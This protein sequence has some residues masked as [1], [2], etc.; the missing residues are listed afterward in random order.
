MSSSLISQVWMDSLNKAQDYYTHDNFKDALKLYSMAKVKS[1]L[2]PHLNQ[3]LA[4]S[5]YRAGDY[6]KAQSTYEGVLRHETESSAKARLYYNIGNSCFMKEDYE[7]AISNYKLS[8]RNNPQNP[9]AKN[10]LSMALR[11][12][13][14]MNDKNPDQKEGKQGAS[15]QKNSGNKKTMKKKNESEEFSF[16]K[17]SAKNTLIKLLR[18]SEE[19]KRRLANKESSNNNKGKDW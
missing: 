15:D 13:Q 12:K 1:D 4:Q 18:K 9:D 8:I 2:E 19:T 17:Q 3:E 5:A 14:Q 16:E 6:E 7:G 10:N 11:K